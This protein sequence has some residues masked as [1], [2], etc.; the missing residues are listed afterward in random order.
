[1]PFILLHRDQVSKRLSET[2]KLTVSPIQ[3]RSSIHCASA[4]RGSGLGKMISS[5]SEVESDSDIKS[6]SSISISA[7]WSISQV[8][9]AGLCS[10]RMRYDLD[11]HDRDGPKVLF[12]NLTIE[13]SAC[14]LKG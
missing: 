6:R 10:C 5:R 12:W 14:R 2:R 13:D 3:T 8:P 9:V 11:M 4:N 7:R 1:L